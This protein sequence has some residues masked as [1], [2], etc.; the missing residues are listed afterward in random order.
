MVQRMS[1]APPA[2]GREP[3]VFCAIYTH[4][5]R[6]STGCAAIKA[7]WGAECDQLL[8]VSD[9][10]DPSL[11]ARRLAHDGEE[12]RIAASPPNTL[13]PIR[14]IARPAASASP[15]SLLIMST[16]NKS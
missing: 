4:H 10:H 9:R 5:P 1:L 13:L 14:R 7:T 8:F 12:G 16:T 15:S 11:P 6:H 2:R 3:T